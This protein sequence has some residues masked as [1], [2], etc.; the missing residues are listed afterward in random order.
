V[1]EFAADR[2]GTSPDSLLPLAI[3]R[4]TL[5]TCRAAYDSWIAVADGDLTSYLDD[6]LRGLSTGFR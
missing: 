3:G 6:A 5:A 1:S 2:L 4:A